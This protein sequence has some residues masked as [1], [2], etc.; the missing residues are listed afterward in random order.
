MNDSILFSETI[1]RNTVEDNFFINGNGER[2]TKNMKGRKSSINSLFWLIII[3]LF[4]SLLATCF[5]VTYFLFFQNNTK[6]ELICSDA[7][8]FQIVETIPTQIQFKTVG[9]LSHEAFLEIIGS[10]KSSIKLTSFYFDLTNNAKEEA[11]GEWGNKIF[12]SLKNASVRGINV[13]I[14]FNKE[15]EIF[16]DLDLFKLKD[17][18]VELISFDCQSLLGGVMH[19]KAVV[20]DNVHFILGSV[21]M[22]WKSFSQVKELGIY[23]RNCSCLAEE[24]TKSF[25]AYKSF[26]RNGKVDQTLSTKYNIDNPRKLNFHNTTSNSSFFLSSSPRELVIEGQ[27][28]DLIS[29]T[30]TIRNA[31]RFVY[32]EV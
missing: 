9:V 8:S 27:T 25:E 11:K 4:I 20:V 30:A 24:M 14:V 10:A 16:K 15:N 21:N 2:F 31:K 7:C 26:A 6:E 3:F 12:E 1:E 18:G 13:E 22:D 23:V 29:I 28:D 32:G 5:F 19:T 17:Y